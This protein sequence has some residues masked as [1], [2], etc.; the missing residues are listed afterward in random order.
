MTRRRAA[1][2]LSVLAMAFAAPQ[3]SRAEVT[4][5]IGG[6]MFNATQP[7]V[8]SGR[9]VMFQTSS[10]GALLVGTGVEALTVR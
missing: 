3:G 8:S 5:L 7:S 2:L 10:R 4:P 9:T 6:G 1:L